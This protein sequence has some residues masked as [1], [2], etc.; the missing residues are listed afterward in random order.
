MGLLAVTL[1]RG[2]HPCSDEREGEWLGTKVPVLSLEMGLWPCWL[3]SLSSGH[4]EEPGHPMKSCLP[5]GLGRVS[6]SDTLRT[7][8]RRS[9]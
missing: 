4:L 9:F 1:P 2:G 7:R 8:G 3:S 6:C 5:P